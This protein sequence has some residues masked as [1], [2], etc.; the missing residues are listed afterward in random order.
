[1][2]LV[3]AGAAPAAA[4]GKKVEATAPPRAP[5]EGTL[6]TRI[7]E[8]VVDVPLRHTDVRIQV[9]GIVAD[10]EVTQTFQNPF[11]RKIEATYLFPLPAAAAVSGPTPVDD[12]R[13]LADPGGPAPSRLRSGPSTIL[14]QARQ[15][16]P[17]GRGAVPPTRTRPCAPRAT[18][19]ER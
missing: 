13:A 8:E 7:G 9:C 12:Q 19:D 11:G 18:P 3:L 6:A 1:M 17:G 10:V 14:Q 4:G 2:A 15:P 16:N 5:S